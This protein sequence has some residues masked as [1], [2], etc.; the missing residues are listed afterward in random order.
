MLSTFTT[1]SAFTAAPRP[2]ASS[3]LFSTVDA[4]SSVN[5]N[6]PNVDE[7]SSPQSL[8]GADV[9]ARLEATLDK[10]RQKDATS[11]MLAKEVSSDKDLR[12]RTYD[13]PSQLVLKSD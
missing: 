5:V 2:S 8:T 7:D 10:L 11:P 1:G 9:R 6:A 3:L 12:S 13:L 4:G